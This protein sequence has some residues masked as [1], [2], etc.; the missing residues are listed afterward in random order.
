MHS[1]QTCN[2]ES[3]MALGPCPWRVALWPLPHEQSTLT[4]TPQDALGS[5]FCPHGAHG[6][7]G[8]LPPQ[9]VEGGAGDNRVDHEELVAGPESPVKRIR[10]VQSSTVELVRTGQFEPLLPTCDLGSYSSR[11]SPRTSSTAPELTATKETTTI[12]N[13]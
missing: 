11:W 5:R 6:P 10:S 7:T 1:M 3:C 8:P 9:R 12:T 4:S 13:A 2:Q